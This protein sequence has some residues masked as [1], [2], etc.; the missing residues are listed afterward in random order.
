MNKVIFLPYNIDVDVA[1]NENIFQAAKRVGVKVPTA[2]NGVGN[3]GL[4]RVKIVSGEE[5]LNKQTKAEIN[6]LGNVYH[7]N[8]KRLC[9]QS[10]FIKDGII[11]VKV[12]E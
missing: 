6:H 5:C 10:K 11:T 3:C 1:S 7:I 4:C 8:K 2:C 12:D 9:C